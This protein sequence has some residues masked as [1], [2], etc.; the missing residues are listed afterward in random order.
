MTGEYGNAVARA[1]GLHK[2]TCDW[3]TGGTRCRPRQEVLRP[4]PAAGSFPRA[5]LARGPIGRTQYPGQ[6]A[7][8]SSRV[9]H[10]GAAGVY[11]VTWGDLV[12]GILRG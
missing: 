12:V 1:A 7:G 9:Q 6:R 8:P 10:P 11:P 2:R 4:S 5:K 3:P